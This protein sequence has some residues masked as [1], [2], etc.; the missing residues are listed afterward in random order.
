MIQNT[1]SSPFQSLGYVFNDKQFKVQIL[2]LIEAGK[3]GLYLNTPNKTISIAVTFVPGESFTWG[4][5]LSEDRTK[6][7][8]THRRIA[9]KLEGKYVYF[10]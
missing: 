7:Y 1:D 9:T 5:P 8:F 4:Q 6:Y 2:P 10:G 3:W